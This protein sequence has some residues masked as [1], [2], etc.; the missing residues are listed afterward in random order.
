M[1]ATGLRAELLECCLAT[2]SYD[3][4]TVLWDVTVPSQ[5]SPVAI[6]TGQS[7]WIQAVAFDTHD[8]LATGS[9][10]GTIVLWDTARLDKAVTSPVSQACAIIGTGL[11]ER[12]WTQYAGGSPYKTT[13]ETS[14]RPR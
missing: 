2:G 1:A 14:H 6:L 5:P 10:D 11:S 9:W 13:C 3:K 7:D 12:Q 8:H 4:T